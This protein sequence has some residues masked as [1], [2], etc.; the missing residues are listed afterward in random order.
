MEEIKKII[1]DPE[2]REGLKHIV[3][4]VLWILKKSRPTDLNGT[5]V[6]GTSDPALT[7]QILGGIAAI[8][9]TIPG[10][11]KITPDFEE[12][13]LEGNLS[14]RGKIRLIYVLAALI[15]LAL[16]KNVRDIFKK[17]QSKEDIKDEQQ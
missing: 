4:R 13:K 6:F 12:K 9:G 10:D 16:D 5:L 2:D 17:I 11:V 8:Y 14:I 7:G 3:H 1:T 15:R